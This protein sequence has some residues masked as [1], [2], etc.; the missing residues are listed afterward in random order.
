MPKRR[1]VGAWVASLLAAT[2]AAEDKPVVLNDD[3]GWCWFQDE[4]ALVVG[5]R[6]VFGSVAAGRADADPPRR[7]GGHER[8]PAHRGR[9]ALAL[10]RDARREGRALRRP[11][12]AGLRRPRRRPHPRRLGRPRLRQPDP[13]PRH[14]ASRATPP[15][16]ARSASFVPSA[17]RR[18]P[19]RTSTACRPSASRIYDFFRGLDDRFK[20]SVAWSD[21]GGERFTSGRRRD[22][23]ARGVPS[24]A[25][26]Q[27]RLGRA[28]APSTSPTPRGTRATSTT[29]STTSITATGSS[30][31]RDGTVIRTLAEGLREPVEGTRIFQG[32]ARNVAWVSDLELDGRGTALRRLLRAEGLGGPAARAGR[33]RPPLS[34]RALDGHGLGGPRDRLSRARGSTRARTTTRGASRSCRATRAASSSRR[35]P[36]PRRARR[37]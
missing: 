33:R 22:R 29:A 25:L 34:A 16:G 35:T 10:E 21:D 3:A 26:R 14:A 24:P 18:S 15:R 17:P 30:T 11:R 36:T 1:A 32:D 6:L 2:V 27:V 23:R 8:R 7:R 31:A 5:G 12:R 28:R 4:R 9:Q 37:S 13:L 20:P 19:T